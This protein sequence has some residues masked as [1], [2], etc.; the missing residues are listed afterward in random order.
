M[1]QYRLTVNGVASSVY[2]W[3]PQMPLLYALRNT[4]G[5]H[6][7][8][9]GCGLGQCGACTVLVDNVPTRSCLLKVS[10]AVGR[11]ITTA[12]GLGSPEK[13]HPVQAAFITEQFPTRVRYAGSSMA[14]TLVGI[15]GGGLAPVMFATMFRAFGTTLAISLYLTAALCVTGGALLIARETSHLPLE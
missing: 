15:V 3:D 12:E 6:G 5:L 11:R 10:E 2:A 8:K 9:F 4:L 14:Y 1:P 13:P 7:A